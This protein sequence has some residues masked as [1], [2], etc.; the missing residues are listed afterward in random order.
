MDITANSTAFCVI[1]CIIYIYISANLSAKIRDG[2]VLNTI[3]VLI[4][5]YQLTE[6]KDTYK[7]H[8][9]NT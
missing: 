3:L 4:I 1:V 6:H 5:Q 7:S 8:L 9:L 2:T